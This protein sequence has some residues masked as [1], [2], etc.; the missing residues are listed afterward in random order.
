MTLLNLL[1]VIGN[2]FKTISFFDFGTIEIK[3]KKSC[4]LL[5]NIFSPKAFEKSAKL[6]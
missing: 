5:V 4:H 6:G 3:L 1:I 2:R